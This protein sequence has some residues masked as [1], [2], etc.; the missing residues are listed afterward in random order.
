M[1]SVMGSQIQNF[2]FLSTSQPYQSLT[3]VSVFFIIVA[4]LLFAHRVSKMP[5]PQMPVD[6]KTFAS[7]QFCVFAPFFVQFHS[8]P[9]VLYA[10]IRLWDSL[11]LR[12]IFGRHPLSLSS[13]HRVSS[14][15]LKN[16][17]NKYCSSSSS[18]SSSSC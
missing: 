12:C 1:L 2:T 5:S 13:T 14:L 11:S 17:S 10:V 18:S 16:T 15:S 8:L 4:S 6:A 7:A 9:V 3:S